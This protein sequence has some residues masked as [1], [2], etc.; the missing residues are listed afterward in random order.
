MSYLRWGGSGFWFVALGLLATGVPAGASSGQ[1]FQG[2]L[3]QLLI[4]RWTVD[5]GLPSDNLSDLL[6]TR[7]G[8]LWITSFEGLLRFDGLEFE[9]FDRRRI[10]S[11]VLD[12]DSAQ[13]LRSDG[14][15]A[16][17]EN[18]AGE[19]WIAGQG[20]QILRYLDGGFGLRETA[21]EGP[22]F[23]LCIDSRGRLWTGGRWADPPPDGSPSEPRR[24]TEAERRVVESIACD[25]DSTWLGTNDGQ[26]LEMLKDGRAVRRVVVPG[27]AVDALLEGP[28]GGLWIGYREGLLRWHPGAEPVTQLAGVGVYDLVRDAHGQLWL[29]TTRGLGRLATDGSLTWLDGAGNG[30]REAHALAF[31]HEGDLWVAGRR[32]GLFRLTDRKVLALDAS[33]GLPPGAV[34]ALVERASGGVVVGVDATLTNVDQQFV[35]TPG[36]RL[37]EAAGFE[38]LTLAEDV[39]GRLWA[40]GYLGLLRLSKES[41]GEPLWL[42]EETGFPSS[43]IRVLLADPSGGL[44][45]GTGNRGVLR[46][47]RDGRVRATLDLDSGLIADF[48]FGLAFDRAGGLLISLRGGLQRWH[49]ETG[50]ETWRSGVELPGSLVFNARPQSDGSLWLATDGGLV[51]AVGPQ[52]EWLDLDGGLPTD[53][54]FDLVMD[55]QG[56]LWVSSSRGLARAFR[57]E[58]E[59]GMAGELDRVAFELFDETDGMSS[60]QCT[61][62]RHMVRDARGR[63][64]VPTL[65]GVTLVDPARVERN[66]HPAPVVIKGLRVDDEP[67]PIARP[68][69]LDPGP[70]RIEIDFAVLSLRNPAANQV[71]YRLEGFDSDWLDAGASRR[72]SY[73]GLAPGSYRLRVLGSNDDGLWSREGGQLAFEVRPFVHQTWTFR[74]VLVLAVVLGG[75]GIVRWRQGRLQRSRDVF[76]NLS[77]QRQELISDLERRNA[78]I[79][80]YLYIFSHDF[81]NPLLTIHNFAGRAD[82]DLDRGSVDRARGDLTRI[83]QAADQ[84]NRQLDAL[85]KVATVGRSGA[86]RE[87]IAFARL[88]DEVSL[89]FFEQVDESRALLSIRADEPAD[90]ELTVLGDRQRLSEA[91]VELLDNAL[92]HSRLPGPIP[93]EVGRRRDEGEIVFWVR[94]RGVGIDPAYHHRVFQPL[95]QLDPSR[96]GTGIGLALV[97]RVVEEHGGL[98][99]IRSDGKGRGATVGWRLPPPERQRSRSGVGSRG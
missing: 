4:E 26:V 83:R 88:I 69:R 67:V 61:G 66:P 6:Q 19:L 21:T 50:L 51:R 93:I 16:L 18:P 38:V 84:L 9:V 58:V 48:V 23:D 99:W 43:E 71:L 33:A 77:Q 27:H 62:A 79:D 49:P 28:G 37:P 56:G 7:D 97:A 30:L 12:G 59:Q 54:V 34:D 65:G 1:G 10:S 63:I 3:D 44:W 70:E 31:D 46:I 53:V 39:E 60:R 15:F 80:R 73:T 52:I 24:G 57:S 2:P 45:V 14:F 91:I 75:L 95:E 36:A 68:I 78:E 94:D 47:D 22:V 40:G 92:K 86:I 82:S 64:W 29:A 87:R 81:K 42:Q 13:G 85:L 90:D 96:P 74:A 5:D 41:D 17:A 76:R 35:A 8:F 32:Q 55:D 11:L 72:V 20:G 89:A 25:G 98:L